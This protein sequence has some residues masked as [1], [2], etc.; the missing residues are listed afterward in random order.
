VSSAA[1]TTLQDR[2]P[3]IADFHDLLQPASGQ[4]IADILASCASSGRAAVPVGGGGALA[5]GNPTS[6]SAIGISTGKLDQIIDYQPTDMTLAVQAGATLADVAS[7]L[8]EH[9]QMLPIEAP[10]PDHATI[11]GLLATALTGPRRYGGGSLRDVIIGITVAYPDGTVG[12]AGGLVVK[13]VSGF[14]M[15]RI[16]YGALGTLG[17]IVSANFKILPLPRSEFTVLHPLNDLQHAA[18]ILPSFR[19]PSVRPVALLVQHTIDGWQLA[20]RFEGRESGLKAVVAALSGVLDMS[21]RIQDDASAA[22]WRQLVDRRA[23]DD[24]D[25]VRI[26][27]STAP[28]KIVPASDMAHSTIAHAGLEVRRAEI[29][30]GLGLATLSW[31]VQT[32]PESA[33]IVA[34]IRTAIPD[35]RVTVQAA[36]DAMKREIDVWGEAPES[37]ELMRRLK[38]EFDSNGVLNP[39]R[40]AGMI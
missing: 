4:E 5:L 30:P 14:D 15:M 21:E 33:A 17:V 35:T 3:N 16:H 22:F 25:E 38:A 7:A 32:R 39:G 31:Q 1:D 34:A 10:L 6:G 27:L 36:P 13:N 29:E 40:F 26:Q 18:S 37:I 11:G 28:A 20:A 24:P 19:P 9:G 2:T 23:F 12:K 8:A